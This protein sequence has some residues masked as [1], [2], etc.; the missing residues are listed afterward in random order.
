MLIYTTVIVLEQVTQNLTNNDIK[1]GS[2]QIM[3]NVR[4]YVYRAY[5]LLM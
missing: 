2:N 1:I 5:F 4:K 3:Y